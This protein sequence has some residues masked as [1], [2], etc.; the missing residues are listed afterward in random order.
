MTLPDYVTVPFAHGLIQSKIWL[1]DVLEQ[2]TLSFNFNK[3]YI[4]GSWTGTMGLLLHVRQ[5]INFN[6]MVVIDHNKDHIEHSKYILNSLLC[7]NKIDFVCEDCNVIQFDDG[8]NL[9]INTSIDNI[10]GDNWFHNIP[11]NSLIALQSRTGGHHDEV[12]SI[13]TLHEFNTRYPLQ[14]VF[15]GSKFFPYP[16]NSYTR[17][18][19][20]GRKK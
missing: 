13:G 10:L 12:N 20:I 9:F 8:D 1:C 11:I 15:L 7:Q 5:K 17:F 3:V 16:D 14:P 2:Y 19:K 18:M 6:K 4:I